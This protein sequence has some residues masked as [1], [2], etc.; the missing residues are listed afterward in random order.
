MDSV[1]A[2]SRELRSYLAAKSSLA[3]S[4]LD[5]LDSNYIFGEDG[6]VFNTTICFLFLSLGKIG[7]TGDL[8]AARFPP[9][10]WNKY[11]TVC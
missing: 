1:E 10:F 2:A 11:I 8:M 7:R 6:V 5:H 3:L 9:Y 4:V